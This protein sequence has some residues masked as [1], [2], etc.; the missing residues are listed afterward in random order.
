VLLMSSLFSKMSAIR[1]TL[2]RVIRGECSGD[3]HDPL[4]IHPV[5]PKDFFPN[6]LPNDFV[7]VLSEAQRKVFGICGASD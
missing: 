4:N 3:L 5:E 1:Q 7:P 2:V 6:R